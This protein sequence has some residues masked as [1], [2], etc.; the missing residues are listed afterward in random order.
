M[1]EGFY[2]QN[3]ASKFKGKFSPLRDMFLRP[4]Q[5]NEKQTESWKLN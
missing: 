1:D 4:S 3:F 2:L 5:F